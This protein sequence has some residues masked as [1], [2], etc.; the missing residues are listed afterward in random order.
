MASLKKWGYLIGQYSAKGHLITKKVIESAVVI[1]G[2][3]YFAVSKRSPRKRHTRK[4][5]HI[6]K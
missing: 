4:R 1:D 2:V 3:L 5:R 6:R